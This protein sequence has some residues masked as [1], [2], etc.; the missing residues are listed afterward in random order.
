MF[1]LVSHLCDIFSTL[2]YFSG[3][4]DPPSPRQR[5]WSSATGAPPP[6]ASSSTT[7]RVPSIHHPFISKICCRG[8]CQELINPSVSVSVSVL[9]P[10]SLHAHAPA[11]PQMFLTPPHGPATRALISASATSQSP[12]LLHRRPIPG[13]HC[14][15][16]PP[17]SSCYFPGEER[18]PRRSA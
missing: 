7:S 11:P 1:G 9:V 17:P 14:P 8:S 13:P 3:K 15:S 10:S 18:D 16:P 12:R 2:S 5:H 4:L 6:P